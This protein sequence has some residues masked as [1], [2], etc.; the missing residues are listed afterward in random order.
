MSAQ[1]APESDER[2]HKQRFPLERELRYRLVESAVAGGTGMGIDASSS[3]IAF[4]SDSPLPLGA[5]IE[6]SISWPVE[7]E[8]SC[9]LR[10]VARGRVVRSDGERTACTIDRFEFR[11]QA[12]N[13][14]QALRGTVATFK[15]L[16]LRTAACAARI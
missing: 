4:T 10:L 13:S 2:R 12:R 1:N 15:A 5:L 9:R 11:T 8:D 6:L 14:P 3:G 7:L 16:R